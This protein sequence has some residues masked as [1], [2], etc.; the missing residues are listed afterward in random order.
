MIEKIRLGDKIEFQIYNV[1][2]TVV[3]AVSYRERIG[4]EFAGEILRSYLQRKNRNLILTTK[5]MRRPP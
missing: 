4:I 5:R 2:K 1:E 3:D